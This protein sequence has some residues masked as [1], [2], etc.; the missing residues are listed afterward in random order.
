MRISREKLLAEAEAT[1]FREEVLEKVI[2]LLNLLEGFRSHP[3]LN[4]GKSWKG[5]VWLHSRRLPE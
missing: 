2:L 3:F 5:L 1:G 4:H